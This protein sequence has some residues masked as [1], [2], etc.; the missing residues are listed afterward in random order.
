MTWRSCSRWAT[1]WRWPRTRSSSP[2]ATSTKPS[3]CC[4]PAQKGRRGVSVEKL[5]QICCVKDLTTDCQ[6]SV[7]CS[8]TGV[9]ADNQ[10]NINV[11][12]E[13]QQQQA[14][15]SSSKPA[16]PKVPMLHPKA[17][18][19]A[20]KTKAGGLYRQTRGQEPL[21]GLGQRWSKAFFAVLLFICNKYC[22]PKIKPF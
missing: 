4:C 17:G 5:Q 3:T 2:G 16:R 8:C 6:L 14:L 12:A 22:R 1:Q 7:C 10:I 19:K 21:L 9:L 11:S 18:K 15:F 20:V 13:Q